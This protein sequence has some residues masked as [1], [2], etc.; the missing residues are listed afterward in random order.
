MHGI[1]PHSLILLHSFTYTFW[2]CLN[3]LWE[4]D[5]NRNRY[6]WMDGIY[7]MHRESLIDKKKTLRDTYV[8]TVLNISSIIF[9]LFG[10]I[11]CFVSHKV[12][13]THC[14][15]LY[16]MLW[17]KNA[18]SC[19]SAKPRKKHFSNGFYHQNRASIAVQWDISE[20]N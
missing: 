3:I 17:K 11:R 6:Q 13:S 14:L 8:K 16:P 19:N 15:P 4:K 10:T 9:E 12:F 20:N 2:K 5:N 7:M 18:Q 1:D